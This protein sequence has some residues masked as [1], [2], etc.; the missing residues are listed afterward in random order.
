MAFLKVIIWKCRCG[1]EHWLRDGGYMDA[2]STGAKQL[3]ERIDVSVVEGDLSVRDQLRPSTHTRRARRRRSMSQWSLKD[4]EGDSCNV[5]ASGT[6]WRLLRSGT[7]IA[8]SYRY[9]RNSTGSSSWPGLVGKG[10]L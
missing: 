1:L 3:F 5:I 10:L 7:T 6:Y 2:E 4:C 8:S 9:S